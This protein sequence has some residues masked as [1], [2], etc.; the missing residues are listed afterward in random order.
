MTIID[1]LLSGDPAVQRMTQVYLLDQVVPYTEEGWIHEFLSRFDAQ[2]GTWG[3]G[4]YGP[5]WISTFYTMRDLQS[6]E[7]DPRHPIYQRGLETLVARLWQR[8]G[9]LTEDDCVVAMLVSLLV[10]GR[11]PAP[12]IEEMVGY[13]VT[14]QH[15][16]GGWNC[17][18]DSQISSKSSIHTTLS[19]LEAYADYEK[20]GYSGWLAV[21]DKQARRG[22][23]YLLRKKLIRRETNND[24]ILPYITEFHFPTRWKYDVLRALFY[25]A[26]IRYPHDA[27]MDEGLTLLKDSMQKGYLNKGSTYTGRIHFPM[28]T[29]KVG[30]MNTLRGLRVLQ[31][32]D[33]ERYKHLIGLELQIK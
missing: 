16:D 9:R 11:Y 2:K 6:L 14:R 12:V 18:R 22:Q 1:Y 26:S 20:E 5:K 17:Q 31:I 4:I 7:I 10:Y 3:D 29:S 28:E 8:P 23:E 33:T 19:V 30:R 32:Y 24:L 15:A 25:F 27:R 21:T 13:L